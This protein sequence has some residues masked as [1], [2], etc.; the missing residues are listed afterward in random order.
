MGKIIKGATKLSKIFIDQ[1]LAEDNT[2]IVDA[3]IGNGY[4]TLYLRKHAN[5][6][7]KIIGFDVQEKA[8]SSTKKR[9]REH[10][11]FYN[12]QLIKDGHE[13]FDKYIDMAIDL[14]VYNLGYLPGSD[15]TITTTKDTTIQSITAGIRLLKKNGL[16]VIVVYPGHD[17]GYEEYKT[18]DDFL[19][20]RDQKN[21]DVLKLDYKNQ[22]NNPPVIYVIEKKK[23]G[24][25]K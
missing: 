24:D 25:I 15:K 12:T 13:Y 2:L 11:A 22:K 6:N 20:K 1:K 9:L 17:E 14:I 5:E 4:D 23:F 8:I 10:D 3:T 21:C 18:I 7:C 16:M 19:K